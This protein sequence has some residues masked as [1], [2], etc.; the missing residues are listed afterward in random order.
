MG[1]SA[2]FIS[3]SLPMMSS[4]VAGRGRASALS[5]WGVASA[6]GASGAVAPSAGALAAGALPAGASPAA[7]AGVVVSAAGAAGVSGVGVVAFS[8]STGAGC[9]MS[10]S[11]MAVL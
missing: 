7:G 8:A 10:F 5:L 1:L 6:A 3:R 11:F 2:A 4:C 9:M